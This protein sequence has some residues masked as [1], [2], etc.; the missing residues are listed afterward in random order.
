MYTIIYIYYVSA[1]EFIVTMSHNDNYYC[2]KLYYIPFYYE[3]P[4]YLL[5]L[6]F[7]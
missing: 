4:N 2:K 3:V 5:Y 6:F 1:M 7:D